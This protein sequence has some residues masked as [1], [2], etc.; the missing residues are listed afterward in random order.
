[1]TAR[2]WLILGGIAGALVSRPSLAGNIPLPK[3][4]F[5]STLS[6][7][8]AA[9]LDSTGSE[10][11][12][13]TPGVGVPNRGGY[14]RGHLCCADMDLGR[15][16]ATCRQPGPTT[17]R[18]LLDVAVFWGPVLTG[19][20]TTMIAPVTLLALLGR[21]R[22]PRWLGIVGVI[23]F[24]EQAVETV[25]VFGSAGFTEP[26]GAMNLQLGAGLTATWMLSFAFW[27]AFRGRANFCQVTTCVS[28]GV[29]FPA[30]WRTVSPGI[31][32]T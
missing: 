7:S 16:G 30:K 3:E 14:V 17:A 21:A 20:T 32:R 8:F 28:D 26:G 27:G 22:L 2:N 13:S 6:G 15:A 23:A 25:T 19:A 5:A 10:A 11:P 12:C 31:W 18:A 9:C 1:V 29:T 24:A 4:Q